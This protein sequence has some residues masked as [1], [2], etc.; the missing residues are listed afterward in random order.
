M[1]FP[2]TTE[3]VGQAITKYPVTHLSLV[4][5]QLRRLLAEDVPDAALKRLKAVLVGGAPAPLSLLQE[6]R[7]RGIPVLTTYG[8]TE[9]NAQV[10]TMAPD[11]ANER[12]DTAGR[13]LK[14]RELKISDDGEILVRGSVLCTGY[15]EGPRVEPVVNNEGWFA[16]GDIG[17]IDADGYLRVRGRRDHMLISGG[18]NIHPE[19]IE[20]LLLAIPDVE[21]AIVVAVPDEEFGERPVAFVG[22]PAG[23][24]PEHLA[25]ILSEHLPRFK[26][27]DTFYPWPEEEQAETLKVSRS[28]FAAIARAQL[29]LERS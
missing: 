14:Y 29:G 16:T 17:Q 23:K 15:V 28:R 12:L 27:P 25:A 19:E 5:T 26:I 24:Q 4:P 8:M 11:D 22:G 21:Q 3:S 20:R 1:V 6:A 9:M 7:G 13:L 10:T 18:E 2:A